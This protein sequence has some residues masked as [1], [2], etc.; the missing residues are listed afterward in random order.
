MF[1][2]GLVMTNVCILCIVSIHSFARMWNKNLTYLNRGTEISAVQM[3][4]LKF[5]KDA[6]ANLLRFWNL[7]RCRWPDLPFHVS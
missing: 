5:S 2:F 3:L 7:Y 4:L 1:M 6:T